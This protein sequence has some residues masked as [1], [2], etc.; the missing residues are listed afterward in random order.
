MDIEAAAW[1]RRAAGLARLP[2]VHRLA[3]TLAA[4]ALAAGCGAERVEA[5]DV[6]TPA[7]AGPRA[8]VAFPKAGLTFSAPRAWRFIPGEA[9]LVASTS[10]GL[11]TIAVWRYPRTEPLPRDDAA[12]ETAQEALLGAI[13][14]RDPR[15]EER[16]TRRV[17]V[18]GAPGIEVVGDQRVSGRPRRVRS[19]H[20]YAK[21]AEYVVD[22]YAPPEQFPAVDRAVFR[23]L[24]RS[25]KIDPPRP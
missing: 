1:P 6:K 5:P 17:E 19:T 3:L 11:A 23:P 10:S 24:L 18:D 21:E 13:R 7:T 16:G 25:L 9:P 4:A 2:A 12:L 22:A 8:D 14:T 20:V 15:F